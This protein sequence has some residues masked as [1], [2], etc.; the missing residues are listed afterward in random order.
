M[1]TEQLPLLPTAP[2]APRDQDVEWL[3]CYLQEHHEWFTAVMLLDALTG[4]AGATHTDDKKR[5]IRALAQASPWI[6]SGQK[7]YKHLKH[8]TP[9]EIT[10]FVHW[11]ES[12]AREMTRRAES[13]RKNAHKIIGS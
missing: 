3:E 10:H 8:A 2:E 1:K 5:Q 11:M 12:Q 13:I 7:G 9:Q 4:L 6:I